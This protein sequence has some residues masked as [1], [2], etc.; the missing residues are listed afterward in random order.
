MGLLD[1]PKLPC[2]NCRSTKWWYMQTNHGND[3]RCLNCQQ[4]NDP[5]EKLKARAVLANRLLYLAWFEINEKGSEF[6]I[7]E[8]RLVWNPELKAQYE[9]GCTRAKQIAQEL[10]DAGMKDCLYIEG[11]KKLKICNVMPVHTSTPS[12]DGFFCHAC[13][14]DYW[15]VKELMEYDSKLPPGEA[16]TYR[17]IPIT[18]TENTWDV[19]GIPGVPDFKGKDLH[20]A[21]EYI[22]KILGKPIK[23]ADLWQ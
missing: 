2:P 3:W 23:D 18:Q 22:D 6:D 11:G 4:P 19:N 15:Y 10:K 20:A 5:I 14:N 9:D 12:W 21:T 8:G 1:Y 7:V 13:P 17:G 16:S